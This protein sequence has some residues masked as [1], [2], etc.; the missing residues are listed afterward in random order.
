MLGNKNNNKV[1]PMFWKS[2]IIKKVC[3]SAKAVEMRSM[4]SLT[5]TVQFSAT[6]LEQ[7]LFGEYKNK[8]PI[9]L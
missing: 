2:K 1:S 5:D 9:K 4:L 6:Q 3:H 7:M 8:L